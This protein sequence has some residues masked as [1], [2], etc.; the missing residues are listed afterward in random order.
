MASSMASPFFPKEREVKLPFAT[1]TRSPATVILL[2][3]CQNMHEVRQ[4]H[5]QFVVSG[6]LNH[7]SLC[8]RRLLES[9]VT[10]SEIS[11][12]RSIFERI[13]YL[14][15]FVYNTMIR[16]LMLGKRPYDSLLLFNELLL[17]CLKPDNY[18]YTFVLKACSNQ[19]ALPEGKQVHCQIIKAGISPNT[20]IHS[21]LIHMYTSSGSIVEA[22][23]VLREFSEENTLAKNSM[24]SG[25]LSKG[26]VDK[27]R[28]MFDQMKAKDVASWSAIITGCTKNGMHTEALA[29]FEDMMVSHTLPNESALVSLLSACAHLGALH[30]G[31]WIH[32][33]IDRIGADM[34]IRLST[35]LIDM[36]AKCGDIQS[37]Y[38][39][40]RKMPRRDIVTWGAIISGFAI[41]GQAK[42]CFE[43][44]EEMVADGIYPNGV[45]FVAILSA[46]SH[47][48]YVEE[49]K[50]YFNQMIVD[51]GIRPSI[52]HYGCMV[53]LLGRAGQLKEAEEFIISMP[54]KPNSVIW[55]S[56]LSACRTHNDLNRGSWAFRHL[57]ELEP[58]SG[59]RY[60]LAG[61]M[62]GNAGEKQE[63]T[64]IRKMIED[65]GM[66]TTCGSSFIEVDGTIHEF[67][68]GDTIHNEAAEIYEVWKGLNG[69]L[70]AA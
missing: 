26:H 62:F 4:L 36:Y 30:Q 35:T 58:R 51:L 63:A 46:C 23:C 50:L 43:L 9:Y 7:H 68:V 61:L 65:Q 49:G 60:K 40:F 1:L 41:Y 12:A 10:M 70:E 29:L 39:F 16:G 52:E 6:L 24:I 53:D 59:D 37:G 34:S 33:Y 44:F 28:A 66:E 31:R 17:G 20:H 42:K 54:E 15:V 32:A 45:I 21:S 67:L 22:E 11:Y 48:G 8:G 64:K 2:Q 27:A 19:K 47:A 55:G 18:T 38:K 56:M 13:P 69:L 5:A 25:Y 3:L 14:D 57:I